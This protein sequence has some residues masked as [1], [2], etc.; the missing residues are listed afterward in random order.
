MEHN[1]DNAMQKIARFYKSNLRMPTY[2]EMR[3]V[4]GFRSVN[5]AYKLG[6]K[7]EA[8]GFLTRG[9]K[10]KLLPKNLYGNIKV[11]GL[12]EAGFPSPAEEEIVDTL[13]LDEWLIE[14]RSATYMLEVKGMSMRDAAILPGDF[15]VVERTIHYRINDIVIAEID[16]QWT[17]K[18]LRK[19]NKGYYLEAANPDYPD[20]RPKETLNVAAVVR[21]VIRKY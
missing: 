21:S 19:D 1:I 9:S 3:D 18:Y 17:V 5:S 6:K 4:L 12:V 7:L 10:G 14:N 2:R 8:L 11:L 15:L 13:T 20:I 16:S